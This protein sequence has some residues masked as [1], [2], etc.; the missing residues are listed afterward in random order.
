MPFR[1]RNTF[2]FLYLELGKDV[3]GPAQQRRLF[4]EHRHQRAFYHAF[5]C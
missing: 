1:A 3:S 4:G 2:P 5:R